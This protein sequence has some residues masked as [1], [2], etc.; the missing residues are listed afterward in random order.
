MHTATRPSADA[1]SS[2]PGAP[3]RKPL[4][5]TTPRPACIDA[6]DA[7]LVLRRDGSAPQRFPLARIERILCNR[8]ATWTGAALA[9][10]LSEGVPIVWLDGHGHALG[11]T[12]ARQTRPFAFV[13][14]LETYLELLDWQKRFGN[15][16]T[17]RRLETLTAWAMRA[18]RDGHAPEARHF[19]TLKREYVYLG[20]HPQV[21]GAEGEG[22][23]H[24]LVV[25]RLHREGLQSRY[26]GF[27]GIPL[28]LASH[29][30]SL[31][32]AEL[33]LDCGTLPTS[34]ER[35][36]VAAHLFETWAR[37]REA[38]LLAHLGDLKRHLAR[39]IEAWH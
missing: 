18:T 9:L 26:W 5:L 24:S 1:R 39:E 7:A 4:Y 19:E 25:G 37:Q 3:A 22:W 17:R 36:I 2:A 38:R 34:A 20:Q 31:L 35:G 21:F 10:C 16:M 14:A 28:D 33:N 27:E 6:S 32:W 8:N 11:S 30:A 13:T 23:C 12:Q 29:L 15:W